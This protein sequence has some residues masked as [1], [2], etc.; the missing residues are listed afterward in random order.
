[1]S[2]IAW[3]M[4]SRLGRGLA[5]VGGVL[6]AIGA[7]FLKGRSA[8]KQAEVTK[9]NEASLENLRSRETTNAEV[10]ARPA[11]DRRRDLGK[12]VRD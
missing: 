5:L 6:L 11:D 7:A 12:W 4:S 10:Q 1:V 3:F 2:V 8:G 9:Q